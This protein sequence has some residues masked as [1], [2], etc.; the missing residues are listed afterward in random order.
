MIHENRAC[1]LALPHTAAA[2]AAAAA[3]AD[4]GDVVLG[5][6]LATATCPESRATVTAQ[7]ET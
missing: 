5:K 6:G 7:K 3:A 1:A 2:A 4:G